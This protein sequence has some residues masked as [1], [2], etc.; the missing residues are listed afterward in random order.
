MALGIMMY[1]NRELIWN[2]G[3]PFPMLMQDVP[4]ISWIQ[5]DGHELEHFKCR[6]LIENIPNNLFVRYY[7]DQAQ[8]IVGNLIF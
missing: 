8:Y 5:F 2:V 7:G 6:E 4:Q 1:D 3:Q